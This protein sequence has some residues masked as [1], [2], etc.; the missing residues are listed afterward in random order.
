LIAADADLQQHRDDWRRSQRRHRHRILRHM[1]ALR[2]P[3]AERVD[4]AGAAARG[5]A[6]AGHHPRAVGAGIPAEDDDGVGQVEIL[7][8]H[9]A[10]ADA[11]A[12]RQAD[13]GRLVAHV[14]AI[15]ELFVPWAR[16]ESW[17]RKAAAFDERRRDAPR[18]PRR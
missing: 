9:G 12:L 14:G 5:I 11:D 2:R 16:A 3:L 13:A 8:R 17:W 1:E 7:G 18:G 15:G 4:D 10:L 6:R